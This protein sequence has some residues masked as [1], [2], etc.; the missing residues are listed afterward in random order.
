VLAAK[1]TADENKGLHRRVRVRA[2]GFLV[3]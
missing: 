3:V 2:P 1:T